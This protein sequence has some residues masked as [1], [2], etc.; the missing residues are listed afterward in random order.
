MV[1]KSVNIV[2]KDLCETLEIMKAKMQEDLDKIKLGT[3]VSYSDV[4]DSFLAA[5][6][7]QTEVLITPE[8]RFEG[9]KALA[10]KTILYQV[11]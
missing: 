3:T 1:T 11:K 6:G 5:Q 4:I 9:S 8:G 7:K 2:R 10:G